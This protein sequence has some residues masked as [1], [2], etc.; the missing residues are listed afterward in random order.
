MGYEVRRVDEIRGWSLGWLYAEEY[1]A[2]III[3][4]NSLLMPHCWGTGLP[5]G[6]PTRRTGLV[7]IGGC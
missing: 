3:I 2:I 7:R 5:Y 4:I 1:R 6:L